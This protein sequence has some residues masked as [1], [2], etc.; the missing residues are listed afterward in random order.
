MAADESERFRLYD[1]LRRAGHRFRASGDYARVLEL[2]AQAHPALFI[3]ASSGCFD[4]AAQDTV[5]TLRQFRLLRAG[6]CQDVRVIGIGEGVPA[7]AVDLA[8]PAR[9]QEADLLLA[10]ESL[11]RMPPDPRNA[12]RCGLT[13]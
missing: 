11:M 7:D 9:P 8:L 1:I 5:R 2:F 6:W 10:V 4:L 3:V 13:H 12:A